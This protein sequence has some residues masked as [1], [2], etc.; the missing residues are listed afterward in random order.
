MHAHTMKDQNVKG[1]AQHLIINKHICF[2]L[3]NETH[4]HE[5]VEGLRWRSQLFDSPIRD[6]QGT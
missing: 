6:L 3:R 2:H 4:T 5:R 1:N